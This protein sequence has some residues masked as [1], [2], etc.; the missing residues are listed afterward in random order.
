MKNELFLTFVRNFEKK[1]L[2]KNLE[3][4]NTIENRKLHIA[5]NFLFII[6]ILSLKNQAI[7]E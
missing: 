6:I 7:I 3:A 1:C 5:Q 4:F 2:Q